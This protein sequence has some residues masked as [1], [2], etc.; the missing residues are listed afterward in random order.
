MLSLVDSFCYHFSMMKITLVARGE[1][2][3]HNF[4]FNDASN[5]ASLSARVFLFRCVKLCLLISY[6]NQ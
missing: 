4:L 2:D 5:L 3:G 6:I 1:I